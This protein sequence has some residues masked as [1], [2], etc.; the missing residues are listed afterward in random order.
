MSP[1]GIADPS[2]WKL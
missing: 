1:K 2:G